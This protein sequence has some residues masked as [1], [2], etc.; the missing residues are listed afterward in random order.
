MTL[1]NLKS[2]SVNFIFSL[3]LVGYSSCEDPFQYNPN[4]IVL[5]DDEKDL[6]R[7]NI[8]RIVNQVDSDTLRFILIS[9]THHEYE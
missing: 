2:L 4:E 8:D 5:S 3:L 9:D 1:A 6:N 7:K